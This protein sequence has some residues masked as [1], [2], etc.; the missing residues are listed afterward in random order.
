MDLQPDYDRLPHDS[1]ESG[2]DLD[3]PD[4]SPVEARRPAMPVRPTRPEMP[5]RRRGG[6]PWTVLLA[7]VVAPLPFI[8]LAL[9]SQGMLLPLMFVGGA[10]FAMI[11]LHYLIWGWWLSDVIHRD[12]AAEDEAEDAE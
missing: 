5:Q 9:L 6:F 10:V 11:A 4:R 1:G 7:A 2:E 12:V 8:L 3:D